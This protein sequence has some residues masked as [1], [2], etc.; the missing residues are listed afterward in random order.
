MLHMLP[1]AAQQCCPAALRTSLSNLALSSWRGTSRGQPNSLRTSAP[2]G[3]VGWDRAGRVLVTSRGSSQLQRLGAAAR[4]FG[5]LHD[6]IH[7]HVQSR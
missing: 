5:T 6:G 4:A 2:E 3:G 1:S 7:M